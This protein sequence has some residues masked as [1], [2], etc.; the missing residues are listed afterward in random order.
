MT[1][2][3]LS[4]DLASELE[5]SQAAET[6]NREARRLLLERCRFLARAAARDLNEALARYRPAKPKAS[7]LPIGEV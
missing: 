6:G 1:T 7:L 2:P 4:L 5:L 3:A